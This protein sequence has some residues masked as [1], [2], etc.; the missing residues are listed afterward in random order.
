MPSIR[1]YN[2]CIMPTC[3]K[4][5]GQDTKDLDY[6]V[7]HDH[8]ACSICGLELKPSEVQICHD[9]AIE[10]NESLEL[11]HPRCLITAG[12]LGT[13]E[14]DPTIA[15]K[16]STYNLLNSA[17]LMIDPDMELSVKTNENN[18]MIHH[19]RFIAG[20]SHDELYA[21]QMMLEACLASVRI[22]IQMDKKELKKRADERETLKHEKAKQQ[23]QTSSR[24]VGKPADASDEIILA[25]FMDSFGLKSRAIA[26]KIKR[27]RDKGIIALCSMGIPE[28]MAMANVDKE[29]ME[30][31]RK[32]RVKISE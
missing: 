3:N 12:R 17:R 30:N 7:C 1:E 6:R 31:I 23:A 21:H 4:P 24:P 15:L 9:K 29:L 2:H 10:N 8:R 19:S 27:D 20:K 32:G 26:K 28:A 18:A 11:A 16:Q 25:K 22:A 5:L 14:S 13:L